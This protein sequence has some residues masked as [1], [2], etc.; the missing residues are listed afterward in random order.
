MFDS[1]KLIKCHW[2]QA[3][4]R[5]IQYKLLFVR[6]TLP[7]ESEGLVRVDFFKAAFIWWK[8]SCEIELEFEIN[9]ILN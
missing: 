9:S 2:V 3:S 8:K 5:C 4:A 1:S 7:F 6:N